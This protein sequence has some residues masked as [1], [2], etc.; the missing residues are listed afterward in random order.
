[1]KLYQLKF[2]LL[3]LCFSYSFFCLAQGNSHLDS[4]RLSQLIDTYSS[5]EYVELAILDDKTIIAFDGYSL[6]KINLID[7]KVEKTKRIST[8]PISVSLMS[9][10][11]H[12]VCVSYL[13]LEG[14]K[15]LLNMSVFDAKLDTIWQVS[16]F[17]NMTDDPDISFFKLEEKNISFYGD[18]G[19]YDKSYELINEVGRLRYDLKNDKKYIINSQRTINKDSLC[20]KIQNNSYLF[21][22]KLDLKHSI[23][24]LHYS[25]IFDDVLY[26][27]QED[28]GNYFCYI[29]DFKS[30][31]LSKSSNISLYMGLHSSNFV[32]YYNHKT[33]YIYFYSK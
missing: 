5:S 11:E 18:R 8:L 10:I 22:L 21:N 32:V 29:Y 19:I 24:F 28:K 7:K 16:N 2:F 20:F 25:I 14:K 31:K 1:M 13:N 6:Y 9:S 27:K 15:N 12:Q 3:I 17:I 26:F 33:K 4:I 23:D 30:Q